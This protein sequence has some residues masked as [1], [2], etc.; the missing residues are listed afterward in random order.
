MFGMTEGWRGSQGHVWHD[1]Y[2]ERVLG[3]CWARQRGGRGLRDMLGMAERW[4][5]SEGHVGHSSRLK[6]T[7]NTLHNKIP[8]LTYITNLIL[9]TINYVKFD[10]EPLR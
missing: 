6:Q 5:G 3:S 8:I 9:Y 2:V 1:R 7:L 10:L 4:L